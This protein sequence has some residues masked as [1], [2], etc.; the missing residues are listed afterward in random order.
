MVKKRDSTRQRSGAE[1]VSTRV[2]ARRVRLL[3]ASPYLLL[4]STNG[5][6]VSMRTLLEVLQR[7]GFSCAAVTGSFSPGS[8]HLLYGG[9]QRSPEQQLRRHG[10]TEARRGAVNGL[11]TLDFFHRGLSIRMLNLTESL[12]ASLYCQEVALSPLL[13]KAIQVFQPQLVLTVIR[14]GALHRILEVAGRYRVPTA[15]YLAT[16]KPLVCHEVLQ[17]THL[18]L[19][20]SHFLASYYWEQYGVASRVLC[21]I[22][23][24]QAVRV[25]RRGARFVTMVNPCPAKGLTMFYGIARQALHVLPQ[26]RFLAVEGRWT[27]LEI[28]NSGI[29]LAE[30]QNV[31]LVSCQTDIRQVLARTSIL[32]FPSYWQEAF[33]RTIVEAQLNGI[34]VIASR[35][36]GIPE[37][38]NGAGIL[39]DL[40]ERLASDYSLMPSDDEVRLWLDHLKTLVTDRRARR[41]AGCVAR[42]AAASLI[43]GAV[44]DAAALITYAI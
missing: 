35:R 14:V 38:L 25:A 23:L 26:A 7:S 18:V 32:L 11:P 17:D 30:L 15:L 41:Q 10:I 27:G 28:A 2:G 36:G 33:G 12:S 19:V 1:A 21:P 20:P 31:E 39:I 34:P 8:T 40:P 4:D 44:A 13:E 3:F 5:A 37:A 42:R 24:P 9:D 16:A 6:A 22:I 29:L 43:E